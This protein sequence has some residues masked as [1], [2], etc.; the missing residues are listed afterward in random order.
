MDQ[1]NNNQILPEKP[2]EGKIFSQETVR[3]AARNG[4]FINTLNIITAP[5]QT[6]LK[7]IKRHYHHRYRKKFPRHHK[8]IFIFDAALILVIVFLGAIASYY[9]FL[10][11][12]FHPLAVSLSAPADKIII[13]TEYA[14]NLRVKNAAKKPLHSISVTLVFPASFTVTAPTNANAKNNDTATPQ[15]RE[16]IWQID[17][18][19]AK[20]EMTFDIK[21]I[22]WA[23][24]EETIKIIA[25]TEGQTDAQE[26]FS[27]TTVFNARATAP[28]LLTTLALPE[29][30]LSGESFPI[31]IAYA[32]QSA[33]PLRNP[34]FRFELPSFFKL[35]NKPSSWRGQSIILPTLM[36][37]ERGSL[38][39]NGAFTADARSP[40]VSISLHT[41]IEINGVSI[42]QEDLLP[43][44]AIIPT[45]VKASITSVEKNGS[46]GGLLHLN[47][48]LD[49]TGSETFKD[50]SIC[51]PL[52][53]RLIDITT[54]KG[55]GALNGG[56]YCFTPTEIA[57]LTEIKNGFH[58][59]WPLTFS[60]LKSDSPNLTDTPP[61]NKNTVLALSPLVVLTARNA[62]PVKL[63]L[64]GHELRVPLATILTLQTM[65]RYFTNEGDQLGRGP[66]PPQVGKITRYWIVWSLHSSAN[67]IKNIT[68]RAVLPPSVQWSGKSIVNKGKNMTYNALARETRWTNELLE[69][70]ADGCACAEGG[71]EVSITPLAKDAG[72]IQTLI[73]NFSVFAEDEWTG[74]IISANA[75]EI[76][77]ELKD[78]P[79]AVGKGKVAP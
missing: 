44:M 28:A 74:T 26:H 40:R 48:A 66:L 18:L 73:K 10:K 68:L 55:P 53:A 46:A 1:K 7:P 25:R 69:P 42:S 30:A 17:A 2:I 38:E 54:V 34:T 59:E 14:W 67:A 22:I 47:I 5:A 9:F 50:V 12:T 65:G 76:T 79:L 75:P 29:S 36:P 78:D 56:A 45:G 33:S 37:G 35:S 24:T 6:F 20:E 16:R 41:D 4:I 51:V 21:G 23:K 3:T 52:D 61:S 62:P 15:A 57:E 71:F 58:G 8:K 70:T 32:N 13:G 77:T 19:R 60:L 64:T 49:H 43:S 63:S 11:P 39:L 31:T 72:A 27:E